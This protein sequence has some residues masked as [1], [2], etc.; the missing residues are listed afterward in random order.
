M[1]MHK[2]Q[3]CVKE[4]NKGNETGNTEKK[5]EKKREKPNI[6]QKKRWNGGGKGKG[7]EHGKHGK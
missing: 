7:S 5:E 3:K 2:K 4:S 6:W 1:K